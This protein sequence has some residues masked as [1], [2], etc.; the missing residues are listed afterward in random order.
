MQRRTIIV[1]GPLAFHMR[2]I[3]AAR[4]GENGNEIVTLPLLAARLAGGFI[5]PA[6]TADVEHAVRS[7]LDAG[8]FDQIDAARDLPGFVRAAA[9]SLAELWESGLTLDGKT[10]DN[11]Q[12]ADVAMLEE[13]VRAAL[14][15]GVL[16]AVDLGNAAL[17]R[18][19]HARAVL[20]AIELDRVFHVAPVWRPLLSALHS[21]TPLTWCNAPAA[22]VTWFDGAISVGEVMPVAAEYVLCANARAETVEALRWLRELLAAGVKPHEI[23]MCAAAPEPWD[24]HFLALARDARLPL[25]FAHGVPALATQGGQACAALADILLRGLNQ[26]R[27]RRLASYSLGQS[28]QLADLPRSWRAGLSSEA[29]LGDV[30]QWRGALNAAVAAGCVDISQVLLPAV[31]L[32]ARGGRAAAEAGAL[33]LPPAAQPI[34]AS[35]LSR[36]PAAAIEQAL[37]DI[38][39]AD[40]RDPGACAVWGSA[41]MLAGAP[42]VHMRLIGLASQSWPRRGREDPLLPLHVLA[43]ESAPGVSPAERDRSAFRHLLARASAS[44]VVSRSRRNA[45]GGRQA[46]SPLVA[47][48][49]RDQWRRLRRDRRPSHAFN[50]ADRLLARPVDRQSE[51]RI[52]SATT[53]FLNRRMAALTAHDG[54]VPANHRLILETLAGPQSATSLKTMLRD[55]LA[56]VW[57]YALGWEVPRD[58]APGLGLDAR[59]YGELLHD[60]LAHTVQGFGSAG[61]FAGASAEDVARV[62]ANVARAVEQDWPLRKAVPPLLLWRHTLDLAVAEVRAALRQTVGTGTQSWAELSFGRSA[63][64]GHGD[65]PWRPS[66]KVTLEKSALTVTGVIDRLDRRATGECR[67]TDYKTGAPPPS[68]DFKIRGGAELQRVLY[69]LAVR[70]LLPDTPSI[71]AVL[72]YLRGDQGTS[73]SAVDMEASALIDAVNV[74]VN[75][76]KGGRTVAGIDAFDAFNDHALALPAVTE[77][78]KI[79]KAAARDRALSDLKLVWELE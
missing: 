4:A 14:P 30:A 9:R 61:G 59:S 75:V 72:L 60:L 13:R 31:E 76:L 34:W 5:R 8:G 41:Q 20:G 58:L 45:Q 57:R 73:C 63:D 51:P 66:A 37:R 79:R 35:A 23:G 19:G 17:A 44:C 78:Y 77:A 56:Y 50:E 48:V 6:M 70:Q 2:R 68:A 38:R 65:L 53:C 40:D 49:P 25:Y 16:T 67:V 10:L 7:A 52:A 74:A 21:E 27:F 39:F 18:V 69:T 26:E 12:V 36:A 55:P 32:I 1:D 43:R 47:H 22:S 54:L 33:L 71:T 42:R 28:K 46:P 29:R 11:G 15:A 3:E 62:A 64:D 24:D